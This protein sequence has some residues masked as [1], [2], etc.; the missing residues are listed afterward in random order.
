MVPPYGSARIATG[1]SKTRPF[2]PTL[3][4]RTPQTAS[5]ITELPPLSRKSANAISPV[6]HG[7]S[8]RT[9]P[10]QL[11]GVWQEVRLP[12]PSVAPPE[13][14]PYGRKAV[15]VRDLRDEI[16]VERVE[17]EFEDAYIHAFGCEETCLQYLQRVLRA[18]EQ[19]EISYYEAAY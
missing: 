10:P 7:K 6:S 15:H 5:Q 17:E 19:F 3:Q 14:L 8:T 9:A 12:K 13:S 1:T 11:R 16:R 2:K 4:I 18:T